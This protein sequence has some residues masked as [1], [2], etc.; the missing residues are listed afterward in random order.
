ML[1][2]HLRH[3]S[4]RQQIR[5]YVHDTSLF[6]YKYLLQRSRLPIDFS[7]T[8]K[9]LA[10]TLREIKPFPL[11]ADNLMVLALAGEVEEPLSAIS[12]A[13]DTIFG[14]EKAIAVRSTL[15]RYLEG[16][17]SEKV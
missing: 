7:F 14:P 15:I 12:D 16:Q 4:K 10:D 9:R 2:S 5:A 8:V 17:H 11:L 13:L 6:A 3:R 1:P